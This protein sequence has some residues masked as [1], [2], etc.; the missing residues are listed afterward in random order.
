MT[1]RRLLLAAALAAASLPVAAPAVELRAQAPAPDPRVA[2]LQADAR[3]SAS[4]AAGRLD[5][6]IGGLAEDAVY[7]HPGA[8]LA[9]GRAAVR[10]FAE[11]QP[12]GAFPEAWTPVE[13]AVSPDGT[14][15]YT[16]GV[17]LFR[18][19]AA[20][21]TAVPRFGRYVTAWRR[22]GERWVAAA[23]VLVQPQG[24]PA[25]VLAPATSWP[26]PAQARPSAGAAAAMER[27]D[28]EFAAD[29]NARGPGP[30]FGRF[31]ADEAM[32]WGPAGGALRGPA[33][34][35]AGFGGGPGE[36]RWAPVRSGASADGAL[37]FTVGE[38]EIAAPGANGAPEVV[39]TKYLT[40]WKRQGDGAYR[41]VTDGGN[42]RPAP[43]AR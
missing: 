7:L 32:M 9:E 27:A 42:P 4:V 3:W 12:A 39:Y 41:Y 22:E 1:V 18:V 19:A 24:V 20:G 23:L 13:G 35:A 36:W 43:A 5:A 37:G 38:A 33:T 11:A 31:A 34:I 14:A 28:R 30:A 15:G 10:A 25:P 6:W 2:L 17:A 16:M 26:N 21:G 29:G 40:I 8:P